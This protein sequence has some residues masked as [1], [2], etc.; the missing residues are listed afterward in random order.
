MENEVGFITV[1]KVKYVF[2][3]GNEMQGL[4]LNLAPKVKKFIQMN[5]DNADLLRVMG[6]GL[7]DWYNRAEFGE[8]IVLKCST[9]KDREY[10]PDEKN[11]NISVN[12][13]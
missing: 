7:I 1:V 10:I 8:D 6:N 9:S 13:L 3:D 4:E 11:G 5:K 12:V 2:K